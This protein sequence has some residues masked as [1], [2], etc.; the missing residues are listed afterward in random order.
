MEISYYVECDAISSR[1][2]SANET[3]EACQKAV[4]NQ[5]EP[6]LNDQNDSAE[7]STEKAVVNQTEPTLNDQNEPADNSTENNPADES[8]ENDLD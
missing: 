1:T 8:L 4:F 5:T 6:T 3:T 2:L 7:N